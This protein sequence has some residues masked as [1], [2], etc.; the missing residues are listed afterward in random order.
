MLDLLRQDTRYAA[1][2]LGRSPLFAI[3]SV[4]S[5]AIGVG[6]TTAIVTLANTLLLRPPPEIGHPERVVAVGRTNE[7]RGFDNFS[8]PDF[9]DYREAKSLSALAAMRLDPTPVSLAGPSGGE[10]IQMTSVSGNFFAVLEAKPTLGRFFSLAEDRAP[11]ADP[12]VVLSHRFWTRRYQADPAI[13]GKPIV[14][15]GTPFTVVGV[16]GE[17]FQGP[18]VIAPDMWVPMMGSTPLGVTASMFSQR[19]AV[20]MV[21]IG[22]LAP[23]VGIT[24]AQAE[25][26]AISTRLN[27]QYRAKDRTTRGIVVTPV[28]FFPAN[29]RPVIGGFMMLL[30][31][32]AGLVLVIASTNV[33][34]MML[35]RASVRRREIA[36]RLALGASRKQLV[37]QLVIESLLVF[38]AAAVAGLVV[39]NWLVAGL[40]ALVPKLPVQLL[41][42]PQLDWRVL[43]FTLA[44]SLVTG[45]VAGLVPA[46]QS[47][48][49]DLV[50]A[51]KSDGAGTATKQR[52]R[53]RSG[54][55]VT[56][57]AF[58]MLLLIVAGLF[59]RT[60][61]AARSIDPGFD[62]RGVYIASLNLD[63]ANY[64]STTGLRTVSTMLE[65][66]RSTPGVQSVATAAMLPLDG[67]GMGLGGIQ[68]NGRRAPNG[69]PWDMDWNVVTPDYF[70][71]LA[72]P[73][74]RG[75]AFSE[76]ERAG[77]DVAILNET[78]AAALFPG[79]DAVGRLVMN[80]DR[81]LTVVGIAKDAKYRTLGEAPRNYIYVPLSQRY[82]G[83]MHVLIKT[84]G[85]V[86]VATAMRRIMAEVDP[87]LPILNQQSMVEQTRVSLF[88]QTLA[89]YVSG[90]LGGVA[91]L[92]ALLG[93]YGVT[94]FSVSQRTREIGV[95]VA[96]GAQRSHV[97]AL[98]VRQGVVLAGIGVVVGSLA[99]FGATRLISSLLYGIAPTDL[100]AFGG[101]AALLAA[102]A[103]VASWIPAR[104]ASR[105]DPV[106]ALKSE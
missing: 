57:I 85:A 41:F 87:A 79:E 74:V 93:I 42:D 47:T 56:Q 29:M 60:L 11:G 64:D 58:S 8:Y 19:N 100:V 9:L 38:I 20:W 45:V 10:P 88:P 25:L 27:Q 102:A 14:L 1:R 34:G 84:A 89:L 37:I 78:F 33:A 30:L 16:A 98:V 59:A 50:P 69:E 104:R 70:A 39:A 22:R 31:A 13:V 54:L 5:I 82:M 55:L 51:L 86:P 61:S 66:V 75:R 49:P 73:I 80:D 48:R 103:L 32:V 90:G 101:A 12:V 17:K 68:V 105:V 2:A 76:T 94:A 99:G 53:L 3:V 7:G 95:R 83:R 106:I 97:L 63:L 77:S 62:P 23:N 36:V 15:N 43:S 65:R 18:F 81:P 35:A 46:M 4:L 28:T 67:G 6:A 71:T 52:M 92:L 91:L 96:L 26:S 40:M 21:A 44:M 72:I 24:Q